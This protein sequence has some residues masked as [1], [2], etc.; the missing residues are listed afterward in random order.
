MPGSL[1][2]SIVE[3]KGQF[4]RDAARRTVALLERAGKAHW[5][6]PA[7]LI[8]LHETVLFLRAYPQS[9]RVLRLA[10]RILFSFSDRLRGLAPEPFEDPEISGIAGT[11]LSTNFSYEIVRSL[12][13]RHSIQIDWESYEH[14]DRLGPV[15]ARAIPLAGEDA[16]VEPHV[17]WQRW[18]ESARGNIKWLT[19][20]VDPQTYDLLEIPVRWEVGESQA[21]RSRTRIPRREIFYHHGAFLK[22]SEVSLAAEFAAPKIVVTKITRPRRVLNLIVDTSAVRY[23]EL[24]GFT[25]PDEA[26]VYHADFGRGVDMFFWGVPAEWRL[27]LRAYHCGMFFKNG[28]PIGYVEGLSLFERM[29]VGF[30]LYYTFREGETAWLYAQVL[31]LFREQL[32]VTCYS[33]DPYQLG[34]ENDEAI[35]SG[36]FWFYRKLGFRTTS[37]D[38]AP[39]IER[40]EA[41]IAADRGYRT[42]PATLRRLARAPLIYNGGPEWDGFELRQLGKMPPLSPELVRAKRAPEEARYLRL[43]QRDTV[44]RRKVLARGRKRF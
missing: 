30:N 42:S 1:L 21:S 39:L 37:T 40:E 26:H 25:H 23:R 13:A 16:S 38:I 44:L 19:G 20:L 8:R 32:G 36:A 22:R 15:L 43:M 14:T 12:A 3:M 27:P 17:D 6:D 11:G 35:E 24:Y 7:E 29:E 28:V 2:D 10:D 41:A 18:F 4:G 31:K 34:H 9:P 33:V 5:R